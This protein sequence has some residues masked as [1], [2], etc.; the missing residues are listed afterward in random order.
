MSCLIPEFR[1]NYELFPKQIYFTA[2][3]NDR[4]A[5][6]NTHPKSRREE[7]KKGEPEPLNS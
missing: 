5:Y 7:D 6:L 2:T 1:L 4:K 3:D